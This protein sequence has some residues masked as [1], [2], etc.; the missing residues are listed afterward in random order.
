VLYV[1]CFLYYTLFASVV[2]IYGIGLNKVVECGISKFYNFLYYLKAALSILATAVLSWLVVNFILVPL[3]LVEL[4]PL[5]C[6]LI[7]ICINTFL[8]ALVRL[9]T[10]IT[11]TEFIVSFLIILLSVSESTSILNT[12]IICFSSYIALLC[13]IPFS[14]TFKKRV[15]S[16]GNFLDG[17]YFSLFFIFLAVLILIITT[18]DIGWLGKGVIQ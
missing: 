10:G 1:S 2:L 9:T 11:T 13:T 4:Y 7:F 12:I 18:W 14:I 17:K 6:L 3:N 5:L 16:N 15:C 8:E